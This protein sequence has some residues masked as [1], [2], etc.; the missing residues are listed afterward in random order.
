MG[1]TKGA[2]TFYNKA[3]AIREK[4]VAENPTDRAQR[5]SLA[6]VYARLG[7]TRRSLTDY[8]GAIAAYRK[9]VQADEQLEKEDPD[10]ASFRRGT[11]NVNRMLSLLSL[12]VGNLEEARK[13][14]DQS[15]KLNAQL[16]KDDPKDMEAQEHLANSYFT[17]GAIL[18]KSDDAVRAQEHFDWALAIYSGLIAHNPSYIPGGLNSTYYLMAELAIQ[19]KDGGKALRSARK[20]LQI[21]D[22]LLAIS[23]ANEFARRNQGLAF[24][25]MGQAHELLARTHLAE[26][27]EARSSYQQSLDVWLE[28]RKKGTLIPRYAPRLDEAGQAVARCDRALAAAAHR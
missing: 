6:A 2:V 27:D 12:D 20:E 9:A 7:T 1:D 13:Y 10:N 8:P 16:V 22:R 11:A 4:L 25:Q 26:W 21:A 19:T 5:A 28:L 17:Q 24:L 18:A 3:V 23:S 14:A 15:A